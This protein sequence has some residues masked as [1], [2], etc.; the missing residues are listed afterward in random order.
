[1]VRP[2]RPPGN[3]RAKFLYFPD[4]NHWVLKPGNVAV[5]YET[6]FAFL[7]QHVL[8]EPWQ[9][10]DAAV[11]ARG[12]GLCQAG[13]MTRAHLDKQPGEVSAM[14]DKLAD[15]YDLMNDVLSLGQD[16]C[17]RRS[18]PGRSAPGPASGCSTWPPAPAPRRGPSPPPAPTCV[19]CD[20]S[21]G[22]L[23]VGAAGR[24]P[25]SGRWP[26]RRPGRRPAGCGS[27]PA[28]RWTCRS[29]TGPSTR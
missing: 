19:A 15:R 13:R 17:W 4:E 29:A 1:M 23:R 24:G 9:R 10:P 11:A 6:V 7:A 25:P 8:G 27:W 12:W 2:G 14:F 21:L 5:W 22:M 18:W 28:T 3:G 20:F 26:A 16:R